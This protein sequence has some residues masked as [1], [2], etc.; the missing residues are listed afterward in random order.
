MHELGY[1]EQD[2]QLAVLR[3]SIKRR[4]KAPR[5]I[6]IARSTSHTAAT[7]CDAWTRS[8]R[9]QR[10]SSARLSRS[11]YIAA[12]LASPQVVGMS[13]RWRQRN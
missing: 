9:G 8:R 10:T 7:W 13:Y 11:G 3:I 12:I 6:V 5:A 2:R 1:D 4:R